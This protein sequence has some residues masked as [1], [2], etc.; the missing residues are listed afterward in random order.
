MRA[1][2]SVQIYCIRQTLAEFAFILL[3]AKEPSLNTDTC[4]N[5]PIVPELV[6]NKVSVAGLRLYLLGKYAESCDS[7][8]DCE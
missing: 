4:A 2:C 7:Q 1:L 5:L 6:G 3:I 8:H